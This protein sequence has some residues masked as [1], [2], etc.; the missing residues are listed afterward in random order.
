LYQG[1]GLHMAVTM[2][3]IDHLKDVE[4]KLSG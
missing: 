2:K 1:L 3:T 4:T